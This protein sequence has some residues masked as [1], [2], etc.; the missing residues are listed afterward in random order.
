MANLK[1][2]QTY[3]LIASNIPK[4]FVYTALKGLGFGLFVAT[5]VI[6][7]QQRRGL[8][9]TEATIVDVT[10][11]IT[12]TLGEVPTGMVADTY[13]RRTSMLIGAALMG[14]STVAWPLAPSVPLIVLA[15]AGMALGFTFVSGAEDAFFYESLRATGQA[16][17]YPRLVGRAS[18]TMLGAMAIGSAVSGLLATIDLSVP[19]LVGGGCIMVMFVVVL[20]FKEPPAEETVAESTR[21]PYRVVLRDALVLMRANPALRYPMLYLAFVPLAAIF[22]ETLFVQPQALLLGVPIAGIGFIVM[23]VQLTNITA[24]TWAHQIT[25]HVGETRVIYLVPLVIIAS[26]LLLAALQTLPALA[27]I[28]LIGFVTA[29][30]RPL[31]MSRIHAEVS[32]GI[33][34]TILSMNSLIAMFLMAISE[35]T[36][37]FIADTAGLPA[38]YVTLAGGVAVMSVVLLWISR[39]HFP[40]AVR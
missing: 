34:A 26:L 30:L 13:G 6:Y 12:A 17:D 40:P 29:I 10:F 23:A 16:I 37:G 18:A 14:V 5:W 11:L 38:A 31:V 27:L 19:F 33:R 7:L 1:S 22:M 9:L 35:L 36:L 2:E 21:K 3:R 32:D 39:H 4:Y 8:S 25:A 15:Y 20:T 28:A 24:S